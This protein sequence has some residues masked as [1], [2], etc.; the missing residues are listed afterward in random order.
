MTLTAASES[1]AL[2]EASLGINVLHSIE[3][4]TRDWA[5]T[6]NDGNPQAI[7]SLYQDDAVLWGTVASAL[8][9]GRSAIRQYFERACVPGALP[10]VEI[11][12]QHIRV[13]GEIAVNSGAYLFHVIEHGIARALPA[14]FT[15]VWQLSADGWMIIDHHSSARPSN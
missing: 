4:R 15:L 5:R 13:I 1:P 6:F 14:R 2:S 8:L 10:R 12:Q 7:A 9:T 11:E 3:A